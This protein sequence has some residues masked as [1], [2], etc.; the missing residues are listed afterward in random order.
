M[1]TIKL[2][3]IYGDSAVVNAAGGFVE[4]LLLED[5]RE[6]LFPRQRVGEKDRGGIPVCAPI[7]GPGELAGLAQHGFAR[8]CQWQI[9]SENQ[10][11]VKLTLVNP[12]SQVKN[13][14]SAYAGCV[15]ELTVQL[16]DERLFE[17]L[18]VKNEGD[19]PF[20]C[21]PG[22]HPY[23]KTS[24]AEKVKVAG[25]VFAT[26]KLLA[27]QKLPEPSSRLDFTL[28]ATEISLATNTP[29]WYVVWS[30]DPNRYI[31]VEPTTHGFVTESNLA[32][33]MLAPGETRTF[34]LELGWK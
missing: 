4:T 25:S 13:L 23:F 16:D 15:M 17:T 34:R 6:V 22:F 30:A 11:E 3:N 27:A 18:L 29:A 26:D 10:D 9:E 20:A 19:E 24:D 21:T 5:G 1:E 32:E 12:A 31:C 33:A 28:A 7:F 14:P 8:N 2:T